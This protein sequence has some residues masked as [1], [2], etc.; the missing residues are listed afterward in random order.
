M[1]SRVSLVSLASPGMTHPTVPQRESILY[2][3]SAVVIR[4]PTAGSPTIRESG[5]LSR[6]T[7]KPAFAGVTTPK[8]KLGHAA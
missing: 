3:P 6:S 7:K 4:G 5:N 2:P 8:K 1:V